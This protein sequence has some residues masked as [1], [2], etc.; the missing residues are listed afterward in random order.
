MPTFFGVP[1]AAVLR[2]VPA[3]FGASSLPGRASS[4]LLGRAS[5]LRRAT[6]RLLR[7][8][9]SL[10]A[11]GP[12]DLLALALLLCSHCESQCLAETALAAHGF[13]RRGLGELFVA[14]RSCGCKNT[15]LFV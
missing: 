4:R 1:A 11:L 12:T 15:A 14:G 9:Q 8:S 7:G 13:A 2:G 5:L 3:F 10:A 6:A